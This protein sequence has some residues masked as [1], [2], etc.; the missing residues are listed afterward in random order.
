MYCAD[1]EI[2]V[3]SSI[4]SALV[5]CTKAEHFTVLL[6]ALHTEFQVQLIKKELHR[7][8]NSTADIDGSMRTT[9][10]F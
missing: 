3:P 10:T 5:F 7:H 6:K 2:P 9:V 4:T 1:G 8:L